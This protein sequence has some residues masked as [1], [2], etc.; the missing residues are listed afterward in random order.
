MRENCDRIHKGMTRAEVEVI[1]GPAGDYTTRPAE[2][3]DGPDL[4]YVLLKAQSESCRDGRGVFLMWTAD[5]GVIGVAFHSERA[6]GAAFCPV[7]GIKQDAREN[8]LWRAKRQWRRW[9]PE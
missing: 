9:F 4:S 7:N 1:L 2:L 8:L 5:S 6:S 3:V